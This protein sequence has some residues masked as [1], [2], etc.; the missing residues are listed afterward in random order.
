MIHRPRNMATRPVSMTSSFGEYMTRRTP[1]I[2]DMDGVLVDSG[3]AHHE[4]WRVVAEQ[5]GISVSAE[6][7]G[8]AFG[9]PSRDIIRMIWGSHLDDAAVAK[10]DAAKEAAYRELV[11]DNVPIIPG[12]RDTL[13]ALHAAGHPLA[14]ATSG[15][16][17]NL[18]LV[19]DAG[20]RPFF[21]TTVNGFEI[22]HGKPAPDCFLLAAERL[23]IAAAECIV[24]EDAV[25]GVQAGVAA[26]M[27]VIGFAPDHDGQ[28]LRAAGAAAIIHAMAELAPTTIARISSP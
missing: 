10:I 15:P 22:R 8:S 28:R 14:V 24:I 17:E 12:C 11:R 13:A 9:R 20:L 27:R 21:T 23:K 16:P 26:G 25:V 18:A 6:R 7:F 4:S 5:T 19:L 3:P 1:V 2:F